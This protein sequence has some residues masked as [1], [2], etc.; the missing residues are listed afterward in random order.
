M[1]ERVNRQSRTR[2]S[3]GKQLFL[4]SSVDGRTLIARRFREVL[5]SIVSDL[6]GADAMSEA[7]MVLAR[8]AVT[9]VVTCETYESKLAETGKLDSD[10][11]LP[12]VNALGKL[13]NALGLK[14]RS[15]H[16]GPSPLE[17]YHAANVNRRDPD[18]ADVGPE[19]DEPQLARRINEAIAAV[20]NGS[21]S[22]PRRIVRAT[23]SQ[24]R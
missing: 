20:A 8:R 21:E 17:G 22:R 15:K 24:G 1:I 16:V 3:N 6:G 9:L 19:C 7:E 12:C 23:S 13:L 18:V 11:Y 4:E 5:A 10:A 2:L 14:R